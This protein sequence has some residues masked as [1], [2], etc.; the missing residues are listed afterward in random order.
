MRGALLDEKALRQQHVADIYI[1][2]KGPAEPHYKQLLHPQGVDRLHTAPG[3]GRAPAAVEEAD[4]FMALDGIDGA[5]GDEAR[6]L[7]HDKAGPEALQKHRQAPA[8]AEG[9]PA[10]WQGA[11]A[12][13]DVLAFRVLLGGEYGGCVV[14]L[15][16]PL[17]SL[18]SF[19]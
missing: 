7:L 5:V 13:G 16:E 2:P 15:E 19:L 10:P 18:R 4:V 14:I 3:L 12:G 8:Q 17:H 9:H 6:K 1:L 11:H